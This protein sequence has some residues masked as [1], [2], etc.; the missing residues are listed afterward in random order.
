MR[1]R[2]IVSI[3]MVALLGV[4]AGCTRNPDAAKRKYI[5]S[6]KK[7]M[8]EKK[9]DSAVIQF[10]K[11]LQIDPR[12]SEAH[13][14]LGQAELAQ[15]HWAAAFREFSTATDQDPNNVKAHLAIA[16]LWW[17]A[18]KYND[19]EEHARFVVEH[20]PRNL[21]GYL[22]LG[23]VL[24]GEKHT[25]EAIDIY[26]K[27]IALEPN[28]AGPYLNRGVA[29]ASI[30]QDGPAEQ[31]LHKAIS[32]DPKAMAAYYA[33]SSFYTNKGD[34]K[35]AE[36]TLRLAIQNAPPEDPGPYLRLAALLLREGRTAD[37][38]QV[39]QQLRE[40]QP[41]SA[42]VAVAIG[43]YYLA[44][45]DNNAAVKEFQRGLNIDPKNQDLQLHLLETLIG[46]GKIDEA[47]ALTDKLLK[48]NPGDILARVTHARLLAIKG[49]SQEA[50]VQLREVI[51][52]APENAKAHFIL[53]QVLRQS[54]DFTGA[55][56][57][58]QE[59]LKRQ[60]ENPMVLYAMAETYRDAGDFET[61]REYASRLL[62]LNETNA[63]AHF[64]MATIEIG[65]KDYDAALKELAEVQKTASNDPVLY[66]NRALAYAGQKKYAEAERDFQTALKLYPHYDA[67]M[68]DYVSLMFSTNNPA[69]GVTLASSYAANNPTRA[70]AHFIY[71]SALAR[72]RKFDQA[73]E[74][75][76]RVLQID[77]KSLMSYISIGQI[78][79]ITNRLPDAEAEYKQALQIQPTSPLV[80][81][82]LGNLAVRMGD[83]KSAGKYFQAALNQN[84]HDPIA[85]N[86]LAWVYAAEG[87]NLDMALS[88]ATQA[89]QIAPEIDG[90][91]DTLAWIQYKKGNYHVSVALAE[92]AVRKRPEKPDYRYHLGM[93]L[94]GAGDRDRGRTELQK[95]LQL[96][97]KGADAEEAQKTLA[98]LR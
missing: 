33:L 64:L 74:E 29:Y 67:A 92:D 60:P 79:E 48:D 47:N 86:N 38:E 34:S 91:N 63:S 45:R 11:A 58:M 3:V 50:V 55:K 15:Q 80:N 97:L 2:Y 31:D 83:L 32:V 71:A 62:K 27:A 52:D 22:L 37:G 56:A 36:E 42:V 41:N 76:Q 26:T 51:K 6:G 30:K 19:A 18:R 35:K 44:S 59:A 13:Y 24:L 20:D 57:E 9:Y 7:Y 75:Y 12:Y 65:A 77:P 14:E 1:K 88:L 73:V 25:Q 23:N 39:V 87:E 16:T 28:N 70:R 72:T 53:G 78:Y 10:K 81:N 5:E 49:N 21:D 17:Q 96:N 54:G 90:I 8:E 4:L 69:K 84:A 46:D 89:K 61:A 85:A 93:A 94:V 66:V 43:D 68:A 98:S 82:Y 95:A 40:K